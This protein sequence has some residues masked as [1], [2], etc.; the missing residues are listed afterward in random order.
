MQRNGIRLL[1]PV[2]LAAVATV[3]L[4]VLGG[5]SAQADT[6]GTAQ[7]VTIDQQGDLEHTVRSANGAWQPQLGQLS[8]YHNV[9][10]LT[11]VI[12]AGEDNIFVQ[13]DNGSGP[14]L[15]HLVRHA[16]GTWDTAAQTPPTR[17]AAQELSVTSINGRLA[18]VRLD[19]S[20]TPEAAEENDAYGNFGQ[21]YPVPTDGHKLRSIAAAGV[22]ASTTLRVVELTDDGKS[23]GVADG[24][25]GGW[26][27]GR[28]TPSTSNPN[29]SATRVAAAQVAGQLQVADVVKSDTNADAIPSVWHGILGDAGWSGFN[30]VPGVYGRPYHVAMT[31]AGNDMQ[32]AYTTEDGGLFHTVRHTADGS[33][34]QDAAMVPGSAN[35]ALGGWVS[36]AGV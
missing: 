16:D 27:T 35:K 21:W 4:S 30:S 7:L 11:S 33:W 1:A 8:G 12:R 3:G 25:L 24:S 23:I 28:W 10:A 22:G 14:Q 9:S 17:A 34:Q 19:A 20:G 18:L 15:G 29:L 31:A 32:L 6:P 26:T 13:Y 2:A 36:I 5:A